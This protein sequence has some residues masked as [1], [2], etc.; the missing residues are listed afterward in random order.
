MILL[1][2][3]KIRTRETKIKTRIFS[4]KNQTQT[5]NKK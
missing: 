3:N 2:K 4:K 5:K 1:K